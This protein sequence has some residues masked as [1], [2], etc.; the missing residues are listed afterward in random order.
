M[1]H[2]KDLLKLQIKTGLDQ[3]LVRDEKKKKN[4]LVVKDCNNLNQSSSMDLE[5]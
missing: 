5:N 2:M 3:I 1:Q 4:I